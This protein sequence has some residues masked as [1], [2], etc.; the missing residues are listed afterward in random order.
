MK[1]AEDLAPILCF[2]GLRDGFALGRLWQGPAPL[3]VTAAFD[4]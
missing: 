4:R 1:M 2:P 3:R